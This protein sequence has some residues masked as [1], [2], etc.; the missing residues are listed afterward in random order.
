MLYRRDER[1]VFV[2]LALGSRAIAILGVLVERPGELVSR[3]EIFSAVWPETIVE[4]SNLDVQT[5]A[6]HSR[7]GPQSG[8]KFSAIPLMQ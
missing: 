7:A 3:A 8:T 4:E 5:A 6:L 2:P 1:G